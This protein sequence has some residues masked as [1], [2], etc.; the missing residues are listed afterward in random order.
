VTGVFWLTDEPQKKERGELDIESGSLLLTEGYLIET[1]EV[2]EQTPSST[3]YS[4]RSFVGLE[5][6]LHGVLDGNIDITIP[7]ATVGNTGETQ[8]LRF[9]Q[10][11]MG[12]HINET[13]SYQSATLHLGSPHRDWLAYP[14]FSGSLRV[15]SLGQVALTAGDGIEFSNLPNLTQ[16]EV[17]RLL[18]QP[19]LNFLS[20]VSGQMPD[21]QDFRLRPAIDGTGQVPVHS[22]RRKGSHHDSASNTSGSFPL[23]SIGLVDIEGLNA[24][25]E[26]DSKLR[27]VCSIISKTIAID[28]YD[29]ESRVLNLAASAEAVH[30]ELYDVKRM[31]QSQA[32]EVKRTAVNAVPEEYQSLVRASLSG[33]R[34]MNF[35]ER[36]HSLLDR[37]GDLA[38]DI[39]GDPLSD[40]EAG[41]DLWVTTVKSYRNSFAHQKRNSPADLREYAGQSYV[42]Y[43]SLRWLLSTVLLRQVGLSPSDLREDL[44]RSS[45]YGLFRERAKLS[46]PSIYN[47]VATS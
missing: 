29:V 22:I 19:L 46:W 42:L 35:A 30:R 2:V 9:L 10:V 25:Y 34:D 7:H 13:P 1:M 31:S 6:T 26:V 24:W 18:V 43:E 36:L 38:T 45:S 33:L 47:S 28:T 39:A 3:S 12:A 11:L 23:F 32:N 14:V 4:P 8:E 20:L 17:E 16:A 44:D 41:R 27:P 15:P 37:I 21:V 40:A 5:L